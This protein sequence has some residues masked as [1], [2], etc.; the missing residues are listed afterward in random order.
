MNAPYRI[1]VLFV[2]CFGI[3]ISVNS[4]KKRIRV[5][6]TNSGLFAMHNYLHRHDRIRTTSDTSHLSLPVV[7]DTHLH[8][9]KT[10]FVLEPLSSEQQALVFDRKILLPQHNN[11]SIHEYY[12]IDP[13]VK[14]FL[15]YFVQQDSISINKESD[16]YFYLS[17]KLVNIREVDSWTSYK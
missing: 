14:I 6:S 9:L 17:G 11:D 2:S 7:V 4:C 10:A 15:F 13:G 5:I 1:S 12:F 16:Y 8:T 3:L